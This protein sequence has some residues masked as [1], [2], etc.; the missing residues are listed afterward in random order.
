MEQALTDTKLFEIGRVSATRE[1]VD[2]IE[3]RA[4][5]GLDIVVAGLL[6]RHQAGD[7]GT[8]DKE[9]AQAN[10][11]AVKDGDRILS[12]YEASGMTIWVLTEADR[13]HTT[14]MRPED[15]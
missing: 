6:A 14:L 5:G 7:W 10:D 3:E 9:D 13:S 4:P 8:V 2:A 11:D 12:S 1:L 15:Y